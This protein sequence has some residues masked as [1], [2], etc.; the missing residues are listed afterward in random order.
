MVEIPEQ[1]AV[2]SGVGISTIGRK[3]ATSGLDLTDQA[4]SAA[5]TDAGLRPADIDGIA[6]MGE[7]PPAEIAQ[8][9]GIRHRWTAPFDMRRGGLLAPVMAAVGGVAAGVARH[10][11]VYRTVKMMG[12]SIL[13][14]PPGPDAAPMAEGAGRGDADEGVM[15]DMAPLLTYH[16]YSAANWLAMHARRHM[17]LY[18][19][20]KEQLGWLAVNSR[21]N[22][23]LNQAAIYRDPITLDD[24]LAARPVSDP[25]G[26][27]DC[28]VPID[29]SIAVVVSNADY[30]PD[31]RHPAVHV[32]A[33][34]VAPGGGGWDQR[35]D[36]PNM[37]SVDAARDLWGRT[38][39]RPSDVD[40]AEL[41][42][43]FTY[44]TFAWL[45]ALGLCGPG[46]SGP[47]VEGADRIRI[48]GEL[49]LNTYGGQL[50]AGRMHGYWVLHEACLQLRGQAGPRQVADA[51]VAVVAAGGGPI[52][53]CMLLTR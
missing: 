35:P 49:P 11:L 42:D 4:A 39:L 2:V 46:E 3:T 45:E 18:G 28:D 13:A 1:R 17:Y 9:L 24:Y 37:A 52:A 31:A 40:V 47:F 36:Y 29:G 43:G 5:I 26:L 25:F 7:T 16:A 19:T 30:A 12:G 41:Y 20:T 33:L 10:V 48:G 34:G 21:A 38:D 8:R 53:G 51:D 15:G 32:A 22:A 6:T 23:A 14:P 27:L 50:S 44:L